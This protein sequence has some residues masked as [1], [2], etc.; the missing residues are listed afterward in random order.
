M[1]AGVAVG[2]I[3]RNGGNDHWLV[4][5]K[6]CLNGGLLRCV[7]GKSVP[8]VRAKLRFMGVGGAFCFV[9]DGG[10]RINPAL[11][12]VFLNAGNR[13]IILVAELFHILLQPVCRDAAHGNAL[14]KIYSTGSQG[15]IKNT[16]G[17]F[18]VLAVELKEIAHL[19]KH[20]IIG[21]SIF[22]GAVILVGVILDFWH[23]VCFCLVALQFFISGMFLRR[24]IAAFSDKLGYAFCDGAP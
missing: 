9:V 6:G 21:V 8:A 1:T 3:L 2:H 15:K 7:A 22:Y 14:N 11:L 5:F 19:I 23:G 18:C 4:L 12:A 16:S 13:H 10:Q 17:G 24:E 20:N